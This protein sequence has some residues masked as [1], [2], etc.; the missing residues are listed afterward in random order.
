MK[1]RPYEEKA[2]IKKTDESTILLFIRPV[3]NVNDTSVYHRITTVVSEWNDDDISIAK[4]VVYGLYGNCVCWKY[5]VKC[6]D[7]A[8][9]QYL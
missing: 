9:Y 4:S 1:G 6:R 5:L 3:R 8:W 7:Y 2:D